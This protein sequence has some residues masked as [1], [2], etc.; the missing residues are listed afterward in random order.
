MPAK[1]PGPPSKALKA[2]KRKPRKQQD[3]KRERHR[4]KENRRREK[5][6]RQ[7]GVLSQIHPKGPKLRFI[8]NPEQMTPAGKAG[9]WEE[10][11][12]PRRRGLSH[13]SG[14]PLESVTFNLVFDGFLDAETVEEKITRLERMAA[15]RATRK[16]PPILRLEYGRMGA[17][18]NWV[19]TDLSY[20]QEY[21]NEHLNR[22]YQE[23]EV[24]LTEYVDA[25]LTL[26]HVQRKKDRDKKKHEGGKDGDKKDDKKNANEH[27]ER[28]IYTVKKGDTLSEIAL[29]FLGKA[30]EWK[31]I[32]RLNDIR[33]PSRL[34]VGA[35]LKI[36]RD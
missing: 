20:G 14:Q 15:P 33:D 21:R 13:W 35:K 7:V 4:K 16:Q 6:R 1:K 5:H 18:K 12:R 27:T 8:E 26:S 9:G 24:T 29:R 36:P 23:V 10:I 22:I 19:I 30:T 11:T 2:L 31:R 34:K 28:R 32:A 3:S 17:G 25:E